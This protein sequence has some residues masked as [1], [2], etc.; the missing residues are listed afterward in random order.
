MKHVELRGFFLLLCGKR[1]T[2]TNF[3]HEIFIG[4]VCGYYNYYKIV[5]QNSSG[6]IILFDRRVD[7]DEGKYIHCPF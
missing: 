5:L 1:A 7:N 3:S 4:R 6:T 2:Y